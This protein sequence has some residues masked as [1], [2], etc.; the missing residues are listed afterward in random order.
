MAPVIVV[1]DEGF[2]VLLQVSWQKVVFQQN[3]VLQ[4]LVP[5]L[6]LALGLGMVRG[7]ARMR[8]TL[9]FQPFR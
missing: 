2:D 9:I 1:I 7:S 4:G 3:A 5:A 8:H 6:N